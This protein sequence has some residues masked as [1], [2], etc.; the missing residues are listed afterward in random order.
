[1]NIQFSDRQKRSLEKMAAKLGTSHA[2]VFKTALSLL[3]AVLRERNPETQI[4]IVKDG[5]VLKT[6]VGV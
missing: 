1:M 6:I 3:R 5:R 4:A 2:G